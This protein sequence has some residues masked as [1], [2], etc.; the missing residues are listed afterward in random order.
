ML[1]PLEMQALTQEKGPR[2]HTLAEASIAKMKRAG[3]LALLA[4]Y[5]KK[6]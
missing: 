3:R 5:Q 2:Q 6:S 1:N 4:Y